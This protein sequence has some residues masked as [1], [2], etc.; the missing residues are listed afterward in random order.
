MRRRVGAAARR[1]VRSVWARTHTPLVVELSALAVAVVLVGALAAL[2]VLQP[3]I[4][5]VAVPAG[6]GVWNW[7]HRRWWTPRS[8]WRAHTARRRRRADL[9]DAIDRA[10]HRGARGTHPEH[11]LY[12]VFV[13]PRDTVVAVC[14]VHRPTSKPN[15]RPTI[16]E[17]RTFSGT[18]IEAAA[19]CV[20]AFE[21]RAAAEERHERDQLDAARD[22]VELDR[23]RRLRDAEDAR[24]QAIEE[25]HRAELARREAELR[26]ADAQAHEREQQIDAEALARALKRR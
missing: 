2:V 25:S 20:A 24:L 16:V 15:Q 12:G 22:A 23:L 10:P 26:R 11:N 6:A 21:E 8:S 14:F 5:L 17:T 7:I 1:G 19:A 13:E 18:E 4:V 9:A 3:A